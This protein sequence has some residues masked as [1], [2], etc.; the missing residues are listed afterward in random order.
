MLK[1]IY[2]V[3]YTCISL[4]LPNKSIQLIFFYKLCYNAVPLRL[5]VCN[6]YIYM[7]SV[8]AKSIKANKQTPT[9]YIFYMC[10]I[11]LFQIKQNVAQALFKE[12]SHEKNKEEK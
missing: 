4:F 6:L 7:L 12:G 11:Y 5:C 3:F 9:F 1:C 10:I 8:I 2:Y